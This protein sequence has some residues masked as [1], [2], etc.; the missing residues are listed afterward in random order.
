MGF[1]KLLGSAIVAGGR[2]LFGVGA[3]TE[4]SQ[5]NA[6]EIVRGVGSFIDEQQ[7]TGQE[8]IDMQ[9]KL[10]DKLIEFVQA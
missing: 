7:L 9:M 5:D 8:R 4:K 10:G 3:T 1:I 6:M 2:A